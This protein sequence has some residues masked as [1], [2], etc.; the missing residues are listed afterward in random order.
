MV[1]SEER[2][3]GAA[4]LVVVGD[5]GVQLGEVTQTVGYGASDTISLYIKHHQFR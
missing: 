1:L 2:R 5:E 4:Q 3:D